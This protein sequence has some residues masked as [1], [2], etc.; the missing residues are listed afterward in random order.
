M[1]FIYNCLVILFFIFVQQNNLSAETYFLDF[2]SILNKSSAGK[3]ANEV[4]KN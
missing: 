3:K 4:L 1:K 2:K